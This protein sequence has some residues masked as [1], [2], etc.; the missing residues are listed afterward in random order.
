VF[1]DGA[2][3]NDKQFVSNYMS[4]FLV[5]R[6]PL[7]QISV[8]LYRH[9]RHE[10]LN[11]ANIHMP[12]LASTR[13]METSISL[14]LPSRT[15]PVT[16]LS[17]SDKPRQKRQVQVQLCLRIR[18][19]F[20]PKGP[21]VSFGR[22]RGRGAPARRSRQEVSIKY[23]AAPACKTGHQATYTFAQRLLRSWEKQRHGILG[24]TSRSI[25][26]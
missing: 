21:S 7:G 1:F 16:R 11:I 3:G 25:H 15:A 4:L 19:E 8:Q 9:R 24:S 22:A 5:L 10:L 13:S 2:Q 17:Q 23:D 12:P 18:T 20:S 14:T 26:P 6:L